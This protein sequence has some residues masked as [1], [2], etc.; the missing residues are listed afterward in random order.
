MGCFGTYVAKVGSPQKQIV[1]WK[2][3]VTVFIQMYPWD[4]HLWREEK[5]AGW[6]EGDEELLRK[7]S[8]HLGGPLGLE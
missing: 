3:E 4:Q 8:T 5:E 7:L 6:G 2:L 1:R